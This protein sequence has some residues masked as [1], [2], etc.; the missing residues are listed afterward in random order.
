MGGLKTERA[1]AFN[2][3][4][5]N[6]RTTFASEFKRKDD[7]CQDQIIKSKKIDDFMKDKS[8]PIK[9]LYDGGYLK[10]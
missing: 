4:L 8:I 10:P 7:F 6:L 1:K 5:V 3:E 9:S 2:T